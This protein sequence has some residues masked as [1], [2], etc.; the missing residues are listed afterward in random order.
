MIFLLL[1][2]PG[3]SLQLST[4]FYHCSPV[5]VSSMAATYPTGVSDLGTSGRWGVGKPSN[6]HGFMAVLTSGAL[7]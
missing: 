2:Q 3:I 4:V 7:S 1:T 5:T 6:G